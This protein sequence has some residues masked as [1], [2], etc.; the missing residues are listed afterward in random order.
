VCAAAAFAQVTVDGEHDPHKKWVLDEI[1]AS[2]YDP[3]TSQFRYLCS[4][5]G[6]SEENAMWL[7]VCRYYTTLLYHAF[8]LHRVRAFYLR[9]G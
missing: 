5:E 6:F 3:T 8:V 2:M 4:F 1:T 7:P 9:I